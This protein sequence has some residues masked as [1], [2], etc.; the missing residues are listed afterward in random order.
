MVVWQ[1]I[2]LNTNKPNSATLQHTHFVL[3]YFLHFTSVSFV[4]KTTEIEFKTPRKYWSKHCYV[5]AQVSIPQGVVSL[6]VGKTKW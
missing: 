2:P 6:P 4:N 1:S 3:L 5:Q